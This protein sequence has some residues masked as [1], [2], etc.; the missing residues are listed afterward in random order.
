MNRRSGA[1]TGLVVLGLLG[2]AAAAV[3]EQNTPAGTWRFEGESLA[4]LHAETLEDVLRQVPLLWVERRGAAG[5]PYSVRA[6]AGRQDQLLLVVDGR[7]WR[8]PWSGED[9]KEE[10]PMALV[11][12]VTVTLRPDPAAHGLAALSGVIRVRTRGPTAPRVV[13]RLH[14]SRGSFGERSRRIAFQTPPG[15]VALTVG[16]DEY[17]SEGYPFS[18]VWNGETNPS[19]ASPELS[20]SQRRNL[21]VALHFDARAAGPLE[22]RLH[23]SDWHL[24]RKAPA[25]DA[26]YR[27]RSAF[28]LSLPASPLGEILLSQSH[29]VRWHR[30]GRASDAGLSVRWAKDL[31]PALPGRWRLLGG[32]ERHQLGFTAQREGLVLPRPSLAWFA[33][34]W[35]LGEGKRVSSVLSLR[36]QRD[37]TRDTHLL[38]HL[39]LDLPLPAGLRLATDL[40]RGEGRE[41]WSRD[42]IPDLGLWPDGLIDAADPPPREP[43]L[44]ASLSISGTGERLWGSLSLSRQ[45]GGVDWLQEADDETGGHWRAVAGEARH[46]L[47]LALG[48]RLSGGLGELRS[49]LALLAELE[50]PTSRSEDR[51]FYPLLARGDLTLARPFFKSD[52]RLELR[53]A[54]ELRDGRSDHGALARAELGAELRVLDARF[55]IFL[56]NGLDWPGEEL[57]GFPV[58]PSSLRMGIDWQ[59][60]H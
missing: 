1:L 35:S 7:P 20:F 28:E 56:F 34:R 45:E 2:L 38:G 44:R 16:L 40:T 19:W 55:W 47:G 33:T 41:A 54:L 6:G 57:P 9:L 52:A 21:S 15:D 58:P 22:L 46:A 53:G 60:D 18:A 25:W 39:S 3:A 37:F 43:S 8:D 26:W 30:V 17:F 51:A 59:L 4:R 23:Q 27:E 31:G 48:T 11:E 12:S 49:H 24:D 10:L 42:R 5:L 32:A 36:Y 13:T 50:D 29:L 14:V